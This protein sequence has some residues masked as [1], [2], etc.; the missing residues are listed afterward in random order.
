MYDE[1]IIEKEADESYR[2]I[3]EIYRMY[4][5]HYE[6]VSKPT[7]EADK[8]SRIVFVVHGRNEEA[9]E[10]LFTFLRSIELHPLG[11]FAPY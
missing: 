5:K 6:G 3:P 7:G 9:R 1:G 8:E 2:V 11:F 10:A 4:E